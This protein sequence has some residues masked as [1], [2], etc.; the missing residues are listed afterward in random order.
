MNS[1]ILENLS[2]IGQVTL[3]HVTSV[4]FACRLPYPTK[5]NPIT[6]IFIRINRS[7]FFP[8]FENFI[9]IIEIPLR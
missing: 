2:E 5:G 9:R 1:N 6:L 3:N 7:G 8:N 4:A